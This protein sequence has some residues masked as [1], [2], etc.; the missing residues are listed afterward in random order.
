MRIFAISIMRPSSC[1]A[2]RPSRA[3]CAMASTNTADSRSEEHTSELQSLRHLVCR[4]LLDTRHTEIYTLSLHDA[5][6]ILTWA[7]GR[8]RGAESAVCGDRIRLGEQALRH[9]DIRNIDH[10]AVEL[11]CP[12]PVARRLR[13]G[14]D[15]HR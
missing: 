11:H 13:H 3:A 14:I 10:A 6:P 1:T 15:E 8:R 5:L 9:A 12:A 4:L 2:P 7:S